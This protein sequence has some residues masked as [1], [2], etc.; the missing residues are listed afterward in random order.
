MVSHAVKAASAMMT[1]N[2]SQIHVPTNHVPMVL[3]AE[4]AVGVTRRLISANRVQVPDVVTNAI[5]F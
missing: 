2:V 3:N 1:C 5:T 4:K